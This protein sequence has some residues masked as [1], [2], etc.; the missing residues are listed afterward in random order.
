VAGLHQPSMTLR[1]W[2]ASESSVPPKIRRLV[3]APVQTALQLIRTLV[4]GALPDDVREVLGK[5]GAVRLG[6]VSFLSFSSR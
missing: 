2:R 5:D 4:A 3:L 6:K 1:A